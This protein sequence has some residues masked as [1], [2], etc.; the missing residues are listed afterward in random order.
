M[1]K[2]EKDIFVFPSWKEIIY[3]NF[4]PCSAAEIRRLL[5]RS[6]NKWKLSD[7]QAA[8][9]NDFFSVSVHGQ[10]FKGFMCKNYLHYLCHICVWN[11]RIGEYNSFTRPNIFLGKY[12]IQGVPINMGINWR[13]LYCL[14][15]MQYFFRT[16][17]IAV[18]Q[19]KHLI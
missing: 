12:I 4:L 18:F 1:N 5:F 6:N 17:I 11:H 13:L 19:L 7:L 14:R 8:K 10:R 3:V 2:N 15:S 9:K 16:T